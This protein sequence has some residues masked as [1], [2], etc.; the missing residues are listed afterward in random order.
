LVSVLLLLVTAGCSEPPQREIDQAQTALDLAK[1]AGADKYAAVEYTDA[2]SALQKARAAVDQRDYR[3]ALNYAIDSRQRSQGAIRQAADGKARAQHTAEAVVL[4]IST[5]AATL[6]SRVKA[7][8]AARAPA[9]DLRTAREAMTAAQTRL[10]E[11]RTL[12]GAGNYE[13]ATKTLTEVLGNL[14]AAIVDV[15]KIPQRAARKRR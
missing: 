13:E 6:Q 15:E 9:K 8:E 7:A 12:I 14:D 5:R 11:A 1:A 4:Q 10:Q 2:A 3:Q